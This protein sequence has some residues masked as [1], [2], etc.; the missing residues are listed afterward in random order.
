MT[1]FSLNRVSLKARMALTVS[2]LFVCFV[3][4]ASY[5]T[6]SY[7]ERTFK[8]IIFTQQASLVSNLARSIDDKLS[9]VHT[10]LAAVAA[11]VPPDCVTD[12]LRAQR[13]LDRHSALL[14][15]FDNGIFLIATDG[16]LIAESPYRF[17]RRGRDLRFREWFWQ[18][19]TTQKPY[20]SDPY[21]STHTPGRPA[22]VMTVPVFDGK[23][24]MIGVLTG[25][26]DLMGKNI[27]ADIAR[28]RVGENGYLFI[29]DKNRTLV[30]HP[31]PK[32]IMKPAAA[33]GANCLVDRAFQGFEGSGET[34]TSY[35]VPML[36]TVK[37]LTRASWFLG[38]NYPLA[39]A[40]AP[41]GTV[42][43]SFVAAIIVLNLVLLAL[44][45]LLTRQLMSP[46]SAITR[47]LEQLPEK[48]PEER[49]LDISG[50]DEIGVLAT[51]FN[52]MLATLERQQDSLME[53]NRRI[54]DER[55]F[56]QT[57]IDAIPD[58]I[59]FKD[60]QSV[61]QGCND[62]FARLIAG[63]PRE[64]LIGK[65]DAELPLLSDQA[66]FFRQSDREAMATGDPCRYELWTRLTDKRLILLETIKV[67]FR[68]A[69]GEI[70]GV[71]GIARDI[72]GHK[73]T[74]YK[75]HEQAALLEREIAERQMAQEALA[76]KHEQLE[77][78]NSS[79]EEMI[80]ASIADL[81]RKDR[82]LIQQS[83]QAAMGEMINNIAHQWRQPLNN[84]GLILQNLMYTVETGTLSTQDLHREGDRAMEII[85]Y[86]SRTIDDF[87]NFF[88]QDKVRQDFSVG[89]VISRILDFMTPSLKHNAIGIDADL[90]EDLLATG[91]PNEFSQVVLVIL[92]NAKDAFLERMTAE[93]LIRIRVTREHD[94]AVVTIRDNGGGIGEG[95]MDRVFNPYFT[96]KE[97]GKGT[98]IGLYMSKTI[99]E[100]NMHGSLTFRNVDGGAEFRIELPAPPTTA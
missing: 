78:I 9:I 88:R 43:Y 71:I 87:R 18:T 67:P 6:L 29:A 33:P 84:I 23:G 12:P 24:G 21:I 54:E 77:K 76:A 17:G 39:E 93:P 3:T 35:G 16:K 66:D 65:S 75:L 42:R 80:A 57:M 58:M 5:A 91:Y 68:D 7:F 28:T 15:L 32:R 30:V 50:P 98:G 79:L 95:V 59:F 10:S 96:T 81:R 2:L 52:T 63:M 20:I 64:A 48:R 36:L 73:R 92:N 61:Y 22:I 99:I 83:R 97:P 82:L 100:K 46:L 89:A 55:L 44:T 38:A 47:H 70:G 86:M 1:C 69:Q 53:Q 74:E 72:T 51:S 19:V 56:L 31:D 37:R 4:A 11:T 49:R 41:L 94:K 13:F 27:L 25:S 60:R 26:L 40:Y 14:S 62:A 8:E 45:W 90:P 34:V 85:R